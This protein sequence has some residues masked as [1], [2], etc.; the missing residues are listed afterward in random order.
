[1]RYYPVSL[2]ISGR[3]CVV[4]GGGEVAERKARRLVS[5]GADVSVICAS[6]APGLEEMRRSGMLR[7][8]KDEYRAEHLDG[9]FLA[10][11]A[12]NDRDVNEKIF[13]DARDRS[14]LINIVDDPRL[15]DIILPALCERGDLQ[16]AVSTGG[17]SP[18]LARKLREDLEREYGPEY[19]VLLEIMGVLREKILSR[20]Y[21]LAQNKSRFESVVRSD[22]LQ[23]IRKKEWD[24]VRTSILDLTGEDL[25]GLERYG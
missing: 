25:E 9:A 17:K 24:R 18:A 1:V 16:I 19:G 11:G 3:K 23:A 22:I 5:C 2:D 13:R 7:H 21:D 14:V 6:L 4:I 8:V 15:C 12:T 20:G 10:I